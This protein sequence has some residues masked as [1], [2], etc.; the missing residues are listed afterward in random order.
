[1]Q[2]DSTAA[3]YVLWPALILLS[4]C[5]Q[6]PQDRLE[7]LGRCYTAG[8]LLHDGVLLRG[9][10]V[11]LAKGTRD[12]KNGISPTELAMLIPERIHD[13]LYPTGS[14]TD[15]AYVTRKLT[16]W[17]DTSVCQGLKQQAIDADKP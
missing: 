8:L 12:L 15:P 1:M 7:E 14:S 4:A 13:E 9:V 5:S 3:R 16:Q 17:A 11:E 6:S 2:I 10:E